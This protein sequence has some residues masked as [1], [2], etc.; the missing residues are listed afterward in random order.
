MRRSLLLAL[1][2]ITLLLV[3]VSPLVAFSDVPGDHSYAAAIDDLSSRGIINGFADGTFGP[4]KPV[5]RQQFAKM[6][7]RT[8]GIPVSESDVCHFGD[9]Q[10]GGY[11]DP[12]FPDN[13]IAACAKY[14]ITKGT[15]PT[16]FSPGAQISRAQVVTMVVRAVQK[17]QPDIALAD[18]SPSTWGNN[19]DPLH[20]PTAAIAQ[21]SGFLLGLPLADLDPWG[22]MPRGEVAQVLHNVLLLID[23]TSQSTTTTSTTTSTTSTTLPSTTT[24][25]QATTTTTVGGGPTVYV[26]A[27]GTKYHKLG[28][29]YLAQSSIP[30]SLAQAKAQGYTPCGVCRPPV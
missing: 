6:I 19:F 22:V 9:V 3:W 23:S 16:T 12:L 5:T 29:R 7:A 20:G 28:C 17:V 25:T 27:T 14:E 8:M 4:G 11:A 24:T 2:A 18:I 15:S 21:G 26:T 1:A 10:A 13:Y 30:M